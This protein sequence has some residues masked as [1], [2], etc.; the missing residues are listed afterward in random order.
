MDIVVWFV[1][2]KQI[3]ITLGVEAA[4]ETFDECVGTTHAK[5]AFFTSGVFHFEILE[6]AIN[7]CWQTC[8]NPTWPTKLDSFSEGYAKG[9]FDIS[10]L[11]LILLLSQAEVGVIGVVNA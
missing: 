8:I 2:A 4:P 3:E 6:A 9:C 10:D 7:N 11:L 1:V 5:Y